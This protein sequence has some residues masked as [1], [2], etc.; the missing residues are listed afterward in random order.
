[1]SNCYFDQLIQYRALDFKFTLANTDLTEHVLEKTNQRAGTKQVC[2]FLPVELVERMEK[3]LS[4]L[5]MNKRQFIE[6]AV[7]HALDR[8]ESI[9]H[10]VDM[11][12]YAHSDKE[13][14]A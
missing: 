13:E 2:A 7:M 3:V 10:E 11:L 14:A 8:A 5:Q 6:A 1:M 4:P 9:M 12:E